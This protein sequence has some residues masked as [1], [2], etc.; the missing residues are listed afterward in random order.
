MDSFLY[1]LMLIFMGLILTWIARRSDERGRSATT[2]L[3]AMR[4]PATSPGHP[5]ARTDPQRSA[6]RRTHGGYGHGCTMRTGSRTD[7]EE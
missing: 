5:D 1:L 7:Q 2:G 4:D 6:I 3:F